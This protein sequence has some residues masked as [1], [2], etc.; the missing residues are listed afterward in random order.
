MK[1]ERK[2]SPEQIRDQLQAMGLLRVS[3]D[4]IRILGASVTEAFVGSHRHRF[5]KARALVWGVLRHYAGLSY[6]EIGRLTGYDNTTVMHQ[7]RVHCP[8]WSEARKR[9]P[10]ADAPVDWPAL[11]GWP[12]RLGVLEAVL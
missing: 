12:V 6:P 2:V 4:A 1:R 9:G 10:A 8:E 3:E 11:D 7:I 5:S